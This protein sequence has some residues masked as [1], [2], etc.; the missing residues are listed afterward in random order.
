MSGRVLIARSPHGPGLIVYDESL[1]P[2]LEL[3]A[4]LEQGYVSRRGLEM[5]RGGFRVKP[6]D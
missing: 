3:E 1:R 4:I 5:P 2:R 6:V